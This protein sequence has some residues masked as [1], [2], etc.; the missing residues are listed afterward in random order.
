MS[1]FAAWRAR[2][3]LRRLLSRMLNTHLQMAGDG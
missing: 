1:L 2:I 3:A